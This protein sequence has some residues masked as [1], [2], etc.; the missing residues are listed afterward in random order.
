MKLWKVFISGRE[1]QGGDYN[2]SYCG[3]TREK[4][5]STKEKALQFMKTHKNPNKYGQP[6]KLNG[7]YEDNE[8]ID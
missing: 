5:F 2:G 4:F 6:H 3:F 7:P 1:W 8:Y